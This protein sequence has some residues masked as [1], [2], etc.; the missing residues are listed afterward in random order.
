MSH[1]PEL[2]LLSFQ[3]NGARGGRP[4]FFQVELEEFKEA[5]IDCGGVSRDTFQLLQERQKGRK[6][7]GTQLCQKDAKQKKKEFSLEPG[8]EQKITRFWLDSP[9]LNKV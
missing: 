6:F 8:S 3:F 5:A 7:F 9:T 4:V 1:K 2:V